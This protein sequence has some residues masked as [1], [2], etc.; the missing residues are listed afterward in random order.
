ME[1]KGTRKT[2]EGTPDYP[3]IDKPR[4][5]GFTSLHL[6]TPAFPG[7][8]PQ[9]IVTGELLDMND[10]QSNSAAANLPDL[11]F[12]CLNHNFLASPLTS[13]IVNK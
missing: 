5:T 7:C 10:S 6:G 1:V 2:V 4:D 13:M 3:T 8:K 11:L 12:H 9:E